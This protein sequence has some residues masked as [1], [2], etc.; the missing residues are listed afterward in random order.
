MVPS[1]RGLS[2]PTSTSKAKLSYRLAKHAD[3][4]AI[5]RLLQSTFDKND[6]IN[7]EDATVIQKKLEDRMITMKSSD[8]PHAFLVGCQDDDEIA[9][10]LE[11]G[12]MP[13]PVALQR[14]AKE[15][16]GVKIESN[17][18]SAIQPELPFVAN[19]VVDE[20]MRRQRVGFTMLQLAMKI[21]KKW[22]SN[23]SEDAAHP[24]LFLSVDRDNAGAIRFYDRMGFDLMELEKATVGDK[25]YLKKDI[26]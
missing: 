22:C 8:M 6:D 1:A 25:V 11:L 13:S 10:F 16:N 14:K 7:T 24:F 21:A 20:S 5:A 2:Q 3:L 4:P 19:L 23:A 15:W 9:A 17:R 18:Q 26:I 12:T